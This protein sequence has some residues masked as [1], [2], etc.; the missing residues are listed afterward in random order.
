MFIRDLGTTGAMP[1]LEMAMRFAGQR[2]KILAHNIANIDTPG[3]QPRDVDPKSFQAMLAGAIHERR[4]R[5]GGAFGDL[6]WRQTSQIKHTAERGGLTLRP[7]TPGRG[8][9]AHDRN[10]T[11]VEIM[12]KDLVE[13]AG[14]YRV[15]ADLLRTQRSQLQNAIA[16]RVL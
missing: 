14:M 4:A 7:E 11:D 10:N 5:T 9:L 15:A 6:N 2:Q 1:A 13:N 8:I 12:M 16:Q 3:F